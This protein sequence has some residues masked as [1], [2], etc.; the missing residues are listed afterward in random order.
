MVAQ[1]EEGRHEPAQGQPPARGFWA[2]AKRF[3]T[4]GSTGVLLVGVAVLVGT[5]CVVY[6]HP[7]TVSQLSHLRQQLLLR[8]GHGAGAKTRAV[9]RSLSGTDPVHRAWDDVEKVKSRPQQLASVAVQGA[10]QADGAAARGTGDSFAQFLAATSR[11]TKRPH[12]VGGEASV[13]SCAS[14]CDAN[15]YSAAVAGATAAKACVDVCLEE[16]GVKGPA[17]HPRARSAPVQESGS[18]QE[19]AAKRLL[20][21]VQ[22]QIPGVAGGETSPALAS[23]ALPGDLAGI[24]T[25][26]GVEGASLPKA[27]QARLRS[28]LRIDASI[29]AREHKDRALLKQ[30]W[31]TSISKMRTLDA[32]R[33]ENAKSLSKAASRA[34]SENSATMAL[35]ASVL[36][37]AAKFRQDL[38]GQAGAGGLPVNAPKAEQQLE[39]VR[40][41]QKKVE[42]A[43]QFA[44]EI[45]SDETIKWK[46]GDKLV[47]KQLN[48][49]KFVDPGADV[50]GKFWS[51]VLKDADVMPTAEA[52]KVRLAAMSDGKLVAMERQTFAQEREHMRDLGTDVRDMQAARAANAKLLAD[53][54][55]KTAAQKQA[56]TQLLAAEARYQATVSQLGGKSKIADKAPALNAKIL[57]D[58]QQARALELAAQAGAAMERRYGGRMSSAAADQALTAL[59]SGGGG[60]SSSSSV[61][62]SYSKPAAAAAASSAGSSAHA[63]HEAHRRK[64]ASL[65]SGKAAVAKAATGWFSPY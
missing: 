49:P 37:A 65:S 8:N 12:P 60:S 21:R 25:A 50:E 57:R 20:A 32:A 56:D 54:M 64:H 35:D 41:A 44:G 31:E 33:L 4:K 55:A 39:S 63:S 9:R 11:S 23:K 47:K 30:T 22:A 10:G 43:A 7:G 5:V 40:K 61:A 48:S 24:A 34:M 6:E 46:N 14:Q 18:D 53:H 45:L 58:A 16:K 2:G 36:T 38:G 3:L 28:A 52:S 42:Q 51:A 13:S 15:G 62:R 1:E 19:D 27:E 29:A 59:G 17:A 26:L